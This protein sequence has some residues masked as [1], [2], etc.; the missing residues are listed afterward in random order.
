MILRLGEHLQTASGKTCNIEAYLGGGGQG[1]V[2]KVSI[3]GQKLALKWYFEH[4]ATDVQRRTLEY[5]VKLEPPTDRFLWP[6]AIMS[7]AKVPGFGY[8]MK[9]REPRFKSLPD[10]MMR[11][12]EPSFHVLCTAGYELVNNFLEL[13]AKGLCYYDISFGNA[14]LDPESGEV[15]ISDN[16]NVTIDGE[17][18]ASVN[19]TPGFMAPEVVVGASLPC[20][21]T[22]RFSLAVLLFFIFFLAHPLEGRKALEINCLDLPAKRRLYGEKPIFIFDPNDDSN[23]P[24]KGDHDNAVVYWL[25]YPDVFK[26]LFIKSFTD[27]LRNPKNGRIRE[28]EWRREMIRLRDAIV[29]CRYCNIE[30][31]YD[32]QKLKVGMGHKCWNCKS[33]ISLPPRLRIGE[34]IIMLNYNTKLFPHHNGKDYDFSASIGE[35]VRHPTKPD[36]WGLKN[37]SQDNW[38]C[39]F[40]SGDLTVLPPGKTIPFSSGVKISFGIKEGEIRCE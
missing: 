9:L 11:R 12:A 29:Y 28:T 40:P 1:E 13:H 5:L 14:F 19:G 22:D 20:A 8:V 7:A 34:N 37:M 6:I 24:V 4:Q 31:F 26:Q 3:D 39:T 27:G 33:E 21:D 17:Q 2:Y 36:V 38:S 23:R 18:T 35:V 30:N 25:I 15:C 10:L 16:D 32:T